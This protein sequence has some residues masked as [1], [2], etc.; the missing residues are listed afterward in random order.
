MKQNLLF[1]S[2]SYCTL[3]ACSL[4]AC[5]DDTTASHHNFGGQN[6]RSSAPTAVS[7]NEPHVQYEHYQTDLAPAQ[8]PAIAPAQITF[9]DVAGASEAKRALQEF[10]NVVNDLD[11]NVAQGINPSA[12]ILL[13]G[14]PGTGKTLLA[15]ATAH[16][17]NASF[18]PTSG[19]VLSEVSGSKTPIERLRTLFEQA[20]DNA[21]AIIFIDELDALKDY[22]GTSKQL[23]LEMDGFS[24]RD[25]VFV[26][27]ACNSQNVLDPSLLRPGRFDRIIE[28]PL[29]D[30][31]ARRAILALR[32]KV[33]L[34]LQVSTWMPSLQIRRACRAQ[35][36]LR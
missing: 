11:L 22:F 34:F 13:V 24:G 3:A 9:D 15:R 6:A 26:I 14:A 23:G 16:A 28:V 4:V 31:A 25:G 8:L 29:P 36:L 21:P 33:S 10:V 2:F 7:P 32:D 27:A 18:Y 12:G 19:S 5:G 17:V 1:R 35:V 20:R 30:L